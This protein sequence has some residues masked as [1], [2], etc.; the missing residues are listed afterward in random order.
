[1]VEGLV[2]RHGSGSH[3][4]RRPAP[5]RAHAGLPLGSAAGAPRPRRPASPDHDADHPRLPRTA[6]RWAA[7]PPDGEPMTPTR[8]RVVITG[9]GVCPA[10]GF[11]LAT[12][13]DRLVAGRSAVARIARFD[14]SGYPSRIA[15]EIDEAAFDR[16]HDLA[17]EWRLR[18]RIARVAPAAAAPA[19][20]DA[21]VTS[22]TA[23]HRRV[24]VAL[25]AGMGS[26]DHDEV[27]ESCG[28]ARRGG[29]DLDWT[30]FAAV[31]RQVRKP[32][33]AERR[34]PGSIAALVAH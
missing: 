1:A 19:P 16:D 5:A 21:G 34:T 22:G 9:M 12:F 29:P 26:Y 31:L 33:A 6:R 30:A 28:A 25:A 14:A 18:G 17:P 3:R 8:P 2:R 15:A 10:A 4:R 27:F 11:D 7:A 13:G 24:G 23:A 32:R 20:H